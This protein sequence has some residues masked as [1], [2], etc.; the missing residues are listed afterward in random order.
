VDERPITAAELPTPLPPRLA[1]DLNACGWSGE[2]DD[3]CLYV[4]DM[5]AL[6]SLPARAGAK[7]FLFDWEDRESDLIVGCVAQLETFGDTW[8]AR[9]L[10]GWY[11]GPIP[12]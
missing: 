4:L 10:S 11:H 7:V 5:E 6:A 1:C 2:P 9:P 8:R 12:W 3:D